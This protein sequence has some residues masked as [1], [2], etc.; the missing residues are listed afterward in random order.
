MSWSIVPPVVTTTSKNFLLIKSAKSPLSPVET[1]FAVKLRNLK[2]ASLT[3][4]LRISEAL[5]TLSAVKP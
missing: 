3:A 5:T 2:S 4:S 1:R